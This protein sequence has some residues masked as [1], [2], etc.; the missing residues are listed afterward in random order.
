MNSNDY[1]FLAKLRILVGYIGESRQS[2]WW[3][4]SFLDN[5]SEV[6]LAPVAENTTF[7]AQYHGVR[8]AAARVHDKFI[9]VGKDTFHLFRLPEVIEQ[10]LHNYLSR[11]D[12][13]KDVSDCLLDPIKNLNDLSLQDK[14]ADEIGPV[15]MGEISDIEKVK[16][17][18]KVASQYNR[19]FK[20]GNKVFPFFMEEQCSYEN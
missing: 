18:E 10:Q 8:I 12:I 7:L 15:L 14:N 20:N 17:W 2:G 11:E 16:T 9:G 4:S 1:I 19:A 5:N 3:S 13:I 6:F